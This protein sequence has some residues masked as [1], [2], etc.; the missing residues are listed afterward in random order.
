VL[1]PE[2][3]LSTSKSGSGDAETGE[4]IAEDSNEMYVVCFKL[5]SSR[6][7]VSACPTHKAR[8]AWKHISILRFAKYS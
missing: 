6:K 7:R 1:V 8:A 4:L 2:V 5:R 3:N